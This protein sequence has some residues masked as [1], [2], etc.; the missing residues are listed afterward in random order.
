MVMVRN[1]GISQ[2]IG[3]NWDFAAGTGEFTSRGEMTEGL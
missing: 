2:R 1:P 3:F